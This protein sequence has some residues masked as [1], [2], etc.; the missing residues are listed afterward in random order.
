VDL[1]S[2]YAGTMSTEW[3]VRLCPAYDSEL[4]EEYQGVPLPLQAAPDLLQ[5]SRGPRRIG[6][7]WLAAKHWTTACVSQVYFV[8]P[9]QCIIGYGIVA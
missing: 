7:N 8:P 9:S 2:Y 1:C 5:D 3:V 6:T 4:Y